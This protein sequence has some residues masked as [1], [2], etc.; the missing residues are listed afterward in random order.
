MTTSKKSFYQIPKFLISKPKT[1]IICTIGPSSSSK[2]QIKKMI[3]E[4]MSVARLNLSHGNVKFHKMCIENILEISNEL[5]APVGIL[6]DVPGPKFRIGQI[7]NEFMNLTTGDNLIID[8]TSNNKK[9]SNSKIHN[10]IK[11]WPPGIE[12]EIQEGSE[13]LLD[14]GS[15]KIKVSSI[16][17]EN[18]NCTVSNS[19]ILKSNKSLVIPGKG[20]QLDYFTPETIKSLKFIAS[21]KIDFVGLSYI[22]SEQDV[23]RVKDFFSNKTNQPKLISKIELPLDLNTLGKIIKSSDG[24]MV[25]RGDLGVQ[26]PISKVPSFQKKIIK[27]SNKIG[28]PVI[29][30]TQMLESMIES[31]NPTRAE[32]TDIYNA[33]NDGTD[34]LM[35]SAETS[36]GNFPIKSLKKMSEIALEAEK[37]FD[38][39]N[40]MENRNNEDVTTLVDEAISYGA[41]KTAHSVRAKLIIAFTESGS[42]AGRIASF[43]PEKPILALV[44]DES[45]T[46]KLSITWGVIPLLAPKFFKV[47]DMFSTGSKAALES[48]LAKNG[49]MAVIVVGM[50]IGVPGNTNL[51]RIMKIPEPELND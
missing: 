47:Q 11:V 50:P 20:S 14:D 24:V 10:S 29:T 49:D 16:N 3:L 26:I 6:A 4:G 34:A 9:D 35:L 18:I 42:T 36:I 8:F 15:I 25:A 46:K 13:L 19:G 37:D 1:R 7:E 2:K 21:N 23:E 38:H 43:R 12:N 27:L 41:C 5:D 40:F 39:I 30:A 51:M 45:V 33:V 44:A 28:K 22:R 32:A 31:P 17:K 48:K